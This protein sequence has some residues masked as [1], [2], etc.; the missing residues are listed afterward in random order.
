MRNV[1]ATVVWRVLVSC[2]VGVTLARVGEEIATVSCL[3]VTAHAE[4]IAL[5]MVHH[6]VGRVL[7]CLNTL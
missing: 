7:L 6:G 1:E 4:A 2:S 3:A 5:G